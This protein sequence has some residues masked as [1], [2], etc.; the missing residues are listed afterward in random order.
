MGTVFIPITGSSSGYFANIQKSYGLAVTWGDPHGFGVATFSSETMGGSYPR[1]SGSMLQMG[2][3]YSGAGA[4]D[5]AGKGWSTGFTAGE[6]AMFSVGRSISMDANGN[7]NPDATS[8]SIMGG[9]GWSATPA[10][11][12]AGK[13]NTTFHDR[14]YGS[15]EA[16][17]LTPP[18]VYYSYQDARAVTNFAD[19]REAERSG[20]NFNT[21][22]WDN[23]KDGDAAARM[24]ATNSAHGVGGRLDSGIVSILSHAFTVR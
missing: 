22:A 24:Y 14:L 3:V 17:G 21:A 1:L 7:L 5:L 6:G 8:T 4:A 13:T 18:E 2:I 23:H 16:F 20:G 19:V 15:F 9:I 12:E 11:V 10:S